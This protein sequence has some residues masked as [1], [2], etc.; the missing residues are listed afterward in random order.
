MI[1]KENYIQI[2]NIFKKALIY[3]FELNGREPSFFKR[4]NE[5]SLFKYRKR[6]NF[7]AMELMKNSTM[8]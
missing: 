3:E 1:D 7:I 6:R 8:G 5:A 2:Q 4:L